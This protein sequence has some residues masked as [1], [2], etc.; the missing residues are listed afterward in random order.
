M[1]P[2]IMLRICPMSS[3]L[4]ASIAHKVEP[5]YGIHRI[6]II[7]LYPFHQQ[8]ERDKP[9]LNTSQM[10]ANEKVELKRHMSGEFDKV[11]SV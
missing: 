7:L 5:I 1:T 10:K 11:K 9:A 4:I 8:F 3:S 2:L 6:E